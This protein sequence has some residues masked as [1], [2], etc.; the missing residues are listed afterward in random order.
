VESHEQEQAHDGCQHQESHY[1]IRQ[2]QNNLAPVVAVAAVAAAV[3]ETAFDPR[4]KVFLDQSVSL[5][6]ELA[7]SC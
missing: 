6:Q 1:H 5:A 3:V 4:S 7:V 2:S